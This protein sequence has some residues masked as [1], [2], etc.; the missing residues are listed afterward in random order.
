MRLS[1]RQIVFGSCVA[2]LAIAIAFLCGSQ[3]AL[4][5][6]PDKIEVNRDIRPILAENCFKCHGP[7]KNVREADL[8]LDIQEGL[9]GAVSDGSAIVAGK[10]QES[11]VLRR[12]KSSAPDEHMPP[13]D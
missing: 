4:A 11:V 7:D 3:L 13:A 2:P 12:I 1:A 10:P 9:F 8:R 6:S 5:D